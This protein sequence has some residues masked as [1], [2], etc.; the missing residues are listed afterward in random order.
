MN[1]DR[2]NANNPFCMPGKWWRGNL[3][4]HTTTSDGLKTPDQWVEQYRD[5]GYDFLV[6]SDHDKINDVGSL[7]GRGLLV[8]SGC[9][10]SA[11]TADGAGYHI[12]AVGVAEEMAREAEATPAEV[13]AFIR[14]QGGLAAIAHP[15]W[16]GHTSAD[17]LPIA[18]DCFALDVFNATCHN[19]MG[20]G[21]AES[22]WDELLDRSGRIFGISCDDAHSLSDAFQGWVMAKAEQLDAPSILSALSAGAFYSTQG[23]VIE[24]CRVVPA[25]GAGEPPEVLVR[26]SPARS[27]TF[28]AYNASGRR[29][30]DRA[31]GLL[32]EARWPI[33]GHEKFIRVVVENA[34]GLRAWSQPFF[35]R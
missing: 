9:E 14:S 13:V 21:H 33:R 2:A 16:S 10:Y 4:T 3:H 24:D 6:L 11:R 35:I 8:I 7:A 23:P 22:H 34:A 12:L 29:I 19:E 18:P 26:C 25:E 5:Q 28:K 27:I 1:E 30:Y 20:K 31:G 32:T 15:Y 17:L